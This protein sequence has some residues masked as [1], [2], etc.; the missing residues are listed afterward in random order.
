MASAQPTGLRGIDVSHHQGAIDWTQV[1]PAGV[2]FAFMKATEGETYVDSEFSTNWAN[3]KAG[4]LLRGAYHFFRA[5]SS[6]ETQ[7]DHFLSTV[8]LSPGDLPPVLD[9][10]LSDGVESTPVIAGV[11]AWL[12]SVQDAVG[13]KPILYTS[14]GFWN[15]LGTDRFGNYP[16]W[17]AHYGVEEPRLPSGW[18]AWTFWQ[19]SDS[20]TTDG[21]DGN[22]DLDVFNGTLEELERLTVKS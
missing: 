10:E 19:Y 14:P 1:H 18:T 7:A 2:R 16:L 22:V 6:A 9:V 12:A 17:V 4:G 3:S 5:G 20:G 8:D 15:G 13:V 21:V 11:Q